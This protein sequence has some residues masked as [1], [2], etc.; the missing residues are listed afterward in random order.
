[1]A[2]TTS[3]TRSVPAAVARLVRVGPPGR[4]VWWGRACLT[5]P[6]GR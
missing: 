1:M 6:G 4:A 3:S 5:A 2:A